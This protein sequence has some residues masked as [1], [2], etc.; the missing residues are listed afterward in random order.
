[1]LFRYLFLVFVIVYLAACSQEPREL[2]FGGEV[3]GTSYSIKVVEGGALDFNDDRLL[4]RTQR[5]VADVLDRVDRA[6]STYKP[7]SELMRFNRSDVGAEF[8]MGAEMR[9][10]THLSLD[11]LRASGGYFD[12]S[13]GPLVSA[14]GFGAESSTELPSQEHVESLLSQAGMRFLEIGLDEKIRKIGVGF[15]DYSAIAKGY[16]VDQAA[17]ALESMGFTNFLVEV[18]GEVRVSG[19]NAVGGSWRLGIEQPDILGRKAYNVAHLKDVAMATSGDYRN[20]I[21]GP[22]GRYS[23]TINPLTGYPVSSE[24]A[25]VSVVMKDCASADAWATA[26]LAMGKDQALEYSADKQIAAFFIFRE[27]NGFS[28]FASEQ[29]KQYLR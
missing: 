28:S 23:H 16:G 20:F 22:E 18:G 19:T 27:S 2:R 6:L 10:V 11:I 5:S 9:D 3:M 17:Q 4:D 1:M 25:S 12:P 13:I 7:E 24:I 14:W 21:D 29:M 15:I 26:L 8:E